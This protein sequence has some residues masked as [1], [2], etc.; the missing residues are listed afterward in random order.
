MLTMIDLVMSLFYGMRLLPVD[1]GGAWRCACGTWNHSQARKCVS[2][3]T[4]RP[5]Q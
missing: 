5:S 2:C 3:G 1:R 4:A